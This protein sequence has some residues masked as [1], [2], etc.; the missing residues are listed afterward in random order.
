MKSKNNAKLREENV[1]Q[2]GK[3]EHH[4]PL[5]TNSFVAVSDII[6]S[7]AEMSSAAYDKW[8]T[9]LSA[10]KYI[11]NYE[12]LLTSLVRYTFVWSTP[13]GLYTWRQCS[14]Y[15]N[16]FRSFLRIYQRWHLFWLFYERRW[17]SDNCLCGEGIRQQ[18][19]C[20][21]DDKPWSAVVKR[22]YCQKS[23][24]LKWQSALSLQ[25]FGV[26]VASTIVHNFSKY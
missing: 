19:K 18:V 14:C 21:Q 4:K 20:A 16:N 3:E 15:V 10:D 8:L 13:V 6:Q 2:L 22:N 24:A 11:I 23:W 7:S 12:W 17:S 5:H 25:F 9:L 1:L 26:R